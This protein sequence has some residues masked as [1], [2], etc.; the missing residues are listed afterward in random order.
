MNILVTG[1][2]GFIG[3]HVCEALLPHHHVIGIDSLI[4]PTPKA[5]KQKTVETLNTYDRFTWIEGDLLS[6]PLDDIVQQVDVIYHFAGMPGVR[7]SWGTSFDLYTTNNI[8]ATQRLLEACKQHRPKQFIYT[9]TSSVYGETNGRVHENTPPAPLSPYGMTKLAG[10]HLCRIYESSFHVPITVLRY[11]TVYGPRQRPDMAFHRFIRQ[12]LFDEPITIFGDGTQTRD[13]TYISD[14]V[15]GTLAVLGNEK[16]IGETFNIGGKERASVNDVIAMLE[17][18]IG[19]QAK[20]QYVN[21]AIG[22]PKH[23]W[24]DISKA[25]NMLAYAPNVPLQEGL[26]REVEY[27]RSLYGRS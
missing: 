19:K 21:Q 5:M 16:A 25:E 23:T 18:L 4:G 1:A 7:T 8:L 17:T 6:L 9:S 22:E 26:R 3:S 12:M 10:E 24:A 14:C 20:K 2:A 13:F 11:F 27:I 15:N